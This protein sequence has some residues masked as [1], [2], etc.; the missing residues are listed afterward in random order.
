MDFRP[1]R[2]W[3]LRRR[4]VRGRRSLFG[5]EADP[6]LGRTARKPALAEWAGHRTP[7]DAHA[8]ASDD[9]PPQ[10]TQLLPVAPLLGEVRLDD[11]AGG[12]A[13]QRITI[14]R[15]GPPAPAPTRPRTIG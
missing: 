6:R 5:A 1:L 2:F 8:T 3:P 11:Q 4:L 12:G 9:A 15:P 14:V 13:G 7:D 10:P